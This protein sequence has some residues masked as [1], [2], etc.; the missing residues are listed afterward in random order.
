[1]TRVATPG[2]ESLI[3]AREFRVQPRESLIQDGE[4]RVRVYV[5][6]DTSTELAC[7]TG[8]LARRNGGLA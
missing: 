5:L 8:E 3:Q 6:T 2:R 4:F 1:M 7:T